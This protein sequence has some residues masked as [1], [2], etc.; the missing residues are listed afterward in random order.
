MLAFT[1][2]F[3][4]CEGKNSQCASHAAAMRTENSL[5]L[6]LKATCIQ[7]ERSGFVIRLVKSV[8][9]PPSSVIIHF[10]NPASGCVLRLAP[11]ELPKEKNQV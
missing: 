1:I 10:Q 7:P 2:N 11:E 3:L 4:F 8:R 6:L 9:C 5:G